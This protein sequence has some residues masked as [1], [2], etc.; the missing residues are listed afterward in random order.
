MSV[1]PFQLDNPDF[2]P[3]GNSPDVQIV[4]FDGNVGASQ[5]FGNFGMG[6]WQSLVVCADV[7]GAPAN[8]YRIDIA[9][10]GGVATGF[11]F[12][13]QSVEVFGTGQV[14]NVVVPV[15]GASCSITLV[16]L[17]GAGNAHVQLD[18]FGSHRPPVAATGLNGG[19][20]ISGAAVALPASGTVDVNAN[21]VGYGVSTFTVFGSTA[22]WKAYVVAI[23][24]G[25]LI[26]Y[27]EPN[28]YTGGTVRFGMPPLR[29]RVTVENQAA[30]A[31]TMYVRVDIDQNN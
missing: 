31:A 26:A 6:G 15:Q 18:V 22:T 28:K 23:T 11:P 1:T 29:T 7:L 4:N 24:E 5:A 25:T 21:A 13:T 14:T 27:V 12:P 8:P 16:R 9:W 2:V 20:L 17:S 30:V 10:Y 3:Y 19:A